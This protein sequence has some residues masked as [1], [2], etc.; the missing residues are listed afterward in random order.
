M[1]TILEQIVYW[2]HGLSAAS[3]FGAIFYR[4]LIVD[5]KA[6]GYFADRADYER[7][8]THLAHGMRYV[9]TAGLLVCG[10]SG[11]ALMG[12]KWEAANA[13]WVN[14][15]I[16]KTIVW[17][18]AGGLFIYVS[19]VHWPFR[20]LAAP[21]EFEKYRREGIVLASSMVLLSGLGFLL[22]QACRL[23]HGG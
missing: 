17:L 21:H 18:L 1:T 4:T 8:S 10:L 15:M 13:A 19:W 22:G 11:F 16:A 5:T 2:V 14:L 23:T 20:S 3:W 7:F 6:F 9:V 12:L